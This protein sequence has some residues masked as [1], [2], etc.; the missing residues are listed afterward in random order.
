MLPTGRSEEGP[1][2]T[3]AGAVGAAALFAVGTSC[4]EIRS[5]G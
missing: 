5:S 3:S 2:L 4:N 1:S